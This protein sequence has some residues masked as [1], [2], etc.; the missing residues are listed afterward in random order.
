MSMHSASACLDRARALLG[1]AL[2]EAEAGEWERVAD[3][4]ARCRQ[5]SRDVVDEL[6]GEDP[7]PLAEGLRQ[8]SGRHHRLLL[9]AEAQ[10]E[11]LV[12]ARRQ[13]VRGRQGARAYENNA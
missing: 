12:E 6:A 5:A 7:A 11:R 2:V 3:L 9:L 4:D 1:E 8:L 13:S 10:R